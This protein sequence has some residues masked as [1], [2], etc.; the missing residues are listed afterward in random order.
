MPDHLHGIIL[1]REDQA[2]DE[3]EKAAPM[4][5]ILVGQFKTH[6]A[7]RIN[8]ARGTRGQPVW[9][10]SYCEHIIRDDEDLARVRTYIANKPLRINAGGRVSINR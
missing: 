2:A 5:G 4:L 8:A 1:I 6:S 9:Q 10:R 7:Q 3:K